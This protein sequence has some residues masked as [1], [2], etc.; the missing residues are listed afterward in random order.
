MIA[1]FCV[2][3]RYF[4]LMKETTSRRT[5]YTLPTELQEGV[6]KYAPTLGLT[7]HQFVNRCVEGILQ[8]LESNDISHDIA[9]LKLG[10]VM[11][12]KTLLES[13]LVTKLCAMFAPNAEEITTWHKRYLAEMLN[14]HEGPLTKEVMEIFWERAIEQNKL[15]VATE[16]KLA[17]AKSKGD[18]K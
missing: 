10:R 1:C 7:E 17:K 12:G 11:L 4:P 18:G 15:R 5:T 9:I 14:Q 16:K 2:D 6:V 3:V 8:G 13:P